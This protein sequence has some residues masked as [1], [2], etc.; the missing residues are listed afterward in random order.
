MRKI[1][2]DAGHGCNTAGKRSPDGKLLEWK[3]NRKTAELVIES[4]KDKGY[5]V[6]YIAPE[7]T[8]TSLGERV[9]R[10]NK[11]GRNALLV[12]I[13]C[14]AAGNGQWMNARGWSIWTTEGKTASDELA[15][16]IWNSAFEMWGKGVVRKEMSDGDVDYEK[17][18]YILRKTLCPAVLV[19]NFFMDNKADCSY[20]L[21][22]QSHIECAAVIVEGIESYLLMEDGKK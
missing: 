4:L 15:T 1:L 9:R 19:E 8:D 21:T 11:F 20:L 10:A 22:E 5:D 12:S 7:D 6:E 2:I 14:N 18:F 17:Q 13:H 3:W 16:C